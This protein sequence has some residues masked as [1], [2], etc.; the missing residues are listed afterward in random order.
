MGLH[1]GEVLVEQLC[2][3]EGRQEGELQELGTLQRIL[4][5]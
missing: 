4:E 2:M 5:N 1:R 3:M